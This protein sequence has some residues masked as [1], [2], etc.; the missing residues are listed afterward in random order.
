MNNI[1]KRVWN[2]NRMVNIE[3]LSGAAFQAE[4]GG[5]TFQISGIDDTGAAVAFSGTVAGVFR[6]PDNADIALT[7][8][9]SDGVASVTLTDDCYAV[10]GRFGLTIFVTSGGQKTAVYAAVGTVAVTSGGGVAGDTPQDVVDLINAISAAVATIPPSYTDL[11]AAIAPTYSNSALYAV[12]SYAWYDGDLYRCTVPITTAETWTAAHWTAATIGG[13]V[14]NLKSALGEVYYSSSPVALSDVQ[15]GYINATIG[16]EISFG[17]QSYWY[18]RSASIDGLQTYKAKTYTS[19][20]TAAKNYFVLVDSSNIVL[21]IYGHATSSAEEQEVTFKSPAN[22]AT[23]WIAC[24]V[25]AYTPSVYALEQKPIQTQIAD[26]IRNTSYPAE[27]EMINTSSGTGYISGSVGEKCSFGSQTAWKWKKYAVSSNETYFATYKTVNN[28]S[29][30]N[31]I[32]SVDKNDYITGI[33]SEA[34]LSSSDIRDKEITI[35]NGSEYV[36]VASYDINIL[37][38]KGTQPINDKVKEIERISVPAIETNVNG[39]VPEFG[40]LNMICRLGYKTSGGTLPEQ[41]VI[42]YR[43]A[44][45][46]GFRIMLADVRATSDHKLVCSHDASINA[47]ARNPDGTAISGTVN[48]AD[49]TLAQADEYDFGIYRGS[50]FAGTKIMRIP[51]FLMFCKTYNCKCI[52]EIKADLTT[53][54]INSLIAYIKMY[55]LS[56]MVMFCN[57][58]QVLQ[59]LSAEFP[60]AIYAFVASELNASNIAAVANFNING[61]AKVIAI[62]INA[63]GYSSVTE[64]NMLLMVQNNID[65]WLTVVYNETMLNNMISDDVIKYCKFIS[66]DYINLYNYFRN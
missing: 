54:E 47:I 37:A 31:Y 27:S 64:E 15:T 53:E 16:S 33:L 65:L 60:K 12:G 61:C 39:Y 34:V 49:I 51:E 8:S 13:D 29:A 2:Q 7:G 57:K 26:I 19:N 44:Y 20:N 35:P 40:G 66:S 11:M 38:L 46:H 21:A 4:D 48:I 43:E 1:I 5:H 32:V 6:R 52:L 62:D 17:T 23:L 9:V 14:S 3:G 25:S 10:S 45:K 55:G 56:E 50:E 42:S 24:A 41:Q 30:V 58:S 59:V 18:R 28:A 63:N 22:A 36:Y